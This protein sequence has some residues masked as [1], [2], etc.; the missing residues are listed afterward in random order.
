MSALPAGGTA[1]GSPAVPDLKSVIPLVED[2]G[3]VEGRR[4]QAICVEVWS[5]SVVVRWAAEPGPADASIGLAGW[6]L[7]D[8]VGTPYRRQGAGGHGNDGFLR[9]E[10]DWRPAPPASARQ[11]TVAY[12][13]P[14]G[15]ERLRATLALG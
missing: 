7:E 1:L 9:N 10:A 8:D 6:S 5:D 2:M 3:D 4:M 13:D 12:R 11:L 14:G 15:T